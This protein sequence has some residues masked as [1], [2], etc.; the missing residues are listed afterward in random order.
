MLDF[1]TLI[2]F[3]ETFVSC[4]FAWTMIRDGSTAVWRID[5]LVQR[6]ALNSYT[7]D[8]DLDYERQKIRGKTYVRNPVP[9]RTVRCIGRLVKINPVF[10]ALLKYVRPSLDS[11]RYLRLRGWRFHPRARWS[12]NPIGVSSI[13]YPC[14]Y[15]GIV[16]GIPR[17][18]D[19]HCEQ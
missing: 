5:R 13:C 3:D 11:W 6:N 9:V 10:T 16:F 7:I 19:L 14:T 12:T 15:R 18:T 2:K 17:A 1:H 4:E 8:A